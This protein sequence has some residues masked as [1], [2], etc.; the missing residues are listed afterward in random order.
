MNWIKHAFALD[1]PNAG[2]TPAQKQVVEK[3][4]A[5]V[6]RR[7]LATPA[8]VFLEVFRPLNYLGSQVMHFFR[9]IVSVIL[10]GDGYR[11]FSE[12]LEHRQSVDYLRGR[13]EELDDQGRRPRSKTKKTPPEA[14]APETPSPSS[15]S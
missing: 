2:P 12:F 13:I 14:G 1:E 8:L 7:G 4:C 15:G 10:D 6:V 3:V 11:H 5:E 9:P